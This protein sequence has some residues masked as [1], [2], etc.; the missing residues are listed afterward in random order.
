MLARRAAP[1]LAAAFLAV[2]PV[3]ASAQ[4]ITLVM[5]GWWG[6]FK[7][8]D[9]EFTS[10]ETSNTWQGRF[11]VHGAGIVRWLT[12]LEADAGGHGAMGP[13]SALPQS[14]F[15]HVVS[16]KSER[17]VELAFRGDPPLGA[18]LSDRE[19]YVNPAKQARDPEAVPDLP[20]EQRRA[21][22]DPISAILSLGRRVAAGDKRFTLPI[23]DGRRRFDLDVTLT[24]PGQH[25]LIGQWRKTIDAIAIVHPIAGFNAYHRRWWS[26]AKFDAFIDPAT[27]LPLQIRSSSFVATVV[28]TAKAMCPPQPDCAVKKD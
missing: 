13:V 12:K 9:I 28:L 1:I 3:R 18:R 25:R 15:Q 7:G 20:E 24:G 6:G 4:P 17:T 8:A 2:A 11:A 10:D 16:N 26:D 27:A 21:T 23:Y 19:I 14:Y 5:Q 22:M